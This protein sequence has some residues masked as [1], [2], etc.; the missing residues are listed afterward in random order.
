MDSF[1]G[2]FFTGQSIKNTDEIPNVESD[3]T[4]TEKLWL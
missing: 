2:Q 1:R 3:R 4:G